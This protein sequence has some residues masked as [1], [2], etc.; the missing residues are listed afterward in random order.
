[1]LCL[2]TA[3]EDVVLP[4]IGQPFLF[5]Y[6]FLFWFLDQWEATTSVT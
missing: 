6:S 3:K 4:S 2:Y 1:M 5:S